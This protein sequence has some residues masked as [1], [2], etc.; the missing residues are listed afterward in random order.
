MCKYEK[1][2]HQIVNKILVRAVTLTQVIDEHC[3]GIFPD[4]LSLDA[5]GYD[6]EILKTVDLNKSSPKIICVEN[7]P[8]LP[9]FK[10][11]FDSMQVTELSQ[12]LMGRNY[13]IAS[14]TPINTIFVRDDFI[15]KGTTE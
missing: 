1:L 6:L 7:I 11:H 12:F 10:N 14:C 13:S 5:E 15:E 2:G 8:Y 9:K 4:F 3:R